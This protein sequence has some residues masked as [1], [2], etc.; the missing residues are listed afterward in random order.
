MGSGLARGP[1]LFPVAWPGGGSGQAVSL[2]AR[3][4]D[5][6]MDMG[7]GHNLEPWSSLVHH[8]LGTRA[9]LPKVTGALLHTTTSS[10]KLPVSTSSDALVI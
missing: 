3:A 2:R 1:T 10:Q 5:D 8:L 6:V 4:A 7:I 9:S